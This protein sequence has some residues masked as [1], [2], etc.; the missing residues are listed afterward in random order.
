M[1]FAVVST[2][3]PYALEI[4]TDGYFK[5]LVGDSLCDVNTANQDWV[6]QSLFAAIREEALCIVKDNSIGSRYA[7]T[8]D[9][10]LS[11]HFQELRVGTNLVPSFFNSTYPVFFTYLNKN[12]KNEVKTKLAKFYTQVD[13]SVKYMQNED[14]SHVTPESSLIALQSCYDY[15]HDRELLIYQNQLLLKAMIVYAVDSLP[16]GCVDTLIREQKLWDNFNYLRAY[17][18]DPLDLN[19]RKVAREIF[20]EVCILCCHAV[21]YRPKIAQGMF[22]KQ[23]VR[24]AKKVKKESI[25]RY[26]FEVYGPQA[27]YVDHPTREDKAYIENVYQEFLRNVIVR[28]LDEKW[29]NMVSELGLDAAIVYVEQEEKTWRELI[30]RQQQVSFPV[31][32]PPLFHSRILRRQR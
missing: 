28:K 19:V 15:L 4:Q 5:N 16:I 32:G 6:A 10:S 25:D 7:L 24:D 14:T 23:L 2:N 17:V 11:K 26:F 8:C 1:S 3:N 21:Q 29:Y 9:L 13:N 31:N 20:A 12:K 22:R 27:G 18:G 30:S